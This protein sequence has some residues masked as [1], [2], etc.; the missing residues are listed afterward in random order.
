MTEC[1][2]NPP[3]FY[4]LFKE[5][6]QVTIVRVVN[7]V[8][9]KQE[10]FANFLR[11]LRFDK[12]RLKLEILIMGDSSEDEVAETPE[13]AAKFRAGPWRNSQDESE[14]GIQVLVRKTKK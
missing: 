11:K 9:I 10:V 7:Y 12:N 1:L 3:L 2:T 8:K 14:D 13:A 5:S 6:R 4:S